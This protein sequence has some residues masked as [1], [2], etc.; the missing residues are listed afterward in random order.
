MLELA[1]SKKGGDDDGKTKK[2]KKK[3][4]KRTE[5][6]ETKESSK[7][8]V[9]ADLSVL[10]IFFCSWWCATCRSKQARTSCSSFLERTARSSLCVSLSNSTDRI[11]DT[12]LQ[13]ELVWVCFWVVLIFVFS[14][15]YQSKSEAKKA[16]SALE[17][18]HLYGRHLVIE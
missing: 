13:S 7:V 2:K 14:L 4:A 6:K 9:K 1:F 10:L 3:K 16:L 8:C 11:A 18:A 12:H 15:R 17:A 5:E